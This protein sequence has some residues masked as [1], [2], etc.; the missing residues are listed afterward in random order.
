[1]IVQAIQMGKWLML[2]RLVKK[3]QDL[4]SCKWITP[5]NGISDA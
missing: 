3:G 1:M 4:I 2:Q 5:A